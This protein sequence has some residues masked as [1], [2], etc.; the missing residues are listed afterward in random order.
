VDGIDLNGEPGDRSALNSRRR[1]ALESKGI[2]AETI[3]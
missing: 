2:S 1:H 3:A